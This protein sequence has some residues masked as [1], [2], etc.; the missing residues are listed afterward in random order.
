MKFYLSLIKELLTINMA[1]KVLKFK[2]KTK[3]FENGMGNANFANFDA[4][5]IFRNFFQGFGG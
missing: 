1:T 2:F 5:D 4:N 3:A